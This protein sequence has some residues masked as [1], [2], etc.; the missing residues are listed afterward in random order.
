M[1]E[2]FVIRYMLFITGWGGEGGEEG[3]DGATGEVE[4]FKLL[5]TSVYV[6]KRH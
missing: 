3:G 6:R 4:F 5:K 1:R 2:N